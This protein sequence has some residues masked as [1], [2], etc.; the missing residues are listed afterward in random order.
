MFLNRPTL[1]LLFV[2]IILL[3]SSV[4]AVAK[5]RS[6]DGESVRLRSGPGQQ[7]GIKWE[8]G[9]GFPLVVLS[10]K[11]GWVKVRDFE[12]DVG[13][14]KGELLSTKPHMIV[15]VNRNK[16]RK[17]NIRSGPGTRF[18]IVG[19][20]YYGVVFETVIRKKR[21]VKVRH[22]SGLVG[23]IKRTLLWGF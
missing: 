7:Y 10:H 2:F 11:K 16:K 17:I 5:M 8:Y 14:I 3:Y 15:K 1:T 12:R 23:W 6:V 13:W 21:W 22:E 18:K 4:D 9:R 20:A 19:K